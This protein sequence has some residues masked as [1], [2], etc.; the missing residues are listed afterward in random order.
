[1]REI[2]TETELSEALNQPE[3]LFFKHSTRCPISSMAYRQMQALGDR[4]FLIRVI[5][6]REISNLL[7][8][9]TKVRHESPQVILCRQGKAVWNA[10]H[11]AITQQA[12]EKA[13]KG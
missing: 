13:L 6:S 12:V 7:A 11:Y 4:V 9:L 10:S 2:L 8:E 3:A 1:M 5:E